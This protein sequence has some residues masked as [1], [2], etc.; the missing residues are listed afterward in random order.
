[1][2]NPRKKFT[3]MNTYLVIT[4]KI[5]I[6]PSYSVF[7]DIDDTYFDVSI[8][9]VRYIRDLCALSTGIKKEHLLQILIFFRFYTLQFS[10]KS[11]F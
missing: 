11:D 2:E 8:V 3:Y 7:L 5:M 6:L 10:V 9:H 4:H 1:M